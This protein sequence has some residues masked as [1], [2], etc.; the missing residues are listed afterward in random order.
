M[1]EK[2]GGQINRPNDGVKCGFGLESFAVFDFIVA[3]AAFIA[4]GA[5]KINLE[6]GRSRATSAGQSQ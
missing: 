5:R 1:I 4:Q 3:P 6:E 2:G